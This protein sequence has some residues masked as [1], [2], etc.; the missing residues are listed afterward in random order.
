MKLSEKELQELQ[1]NQQTS[2]EIIFAIGELELQ[3]ISLVDQYREL[4]QQQNQLGEDLTKKYGDGKINLNT[5]EIVPIEPTP[6]D[7]PPTS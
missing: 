7:N 6:S 2:N 1:S 5:G 3:K 4:A